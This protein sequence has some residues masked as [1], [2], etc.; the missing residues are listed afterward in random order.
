MQEIRSY[1]ARL[2]D[3]VLLLRAPYKS[4][5]QQ[6]MPSIQYAGSLF[7]QSILI[8]FDAIALE[9]GRILGLSDQELRQRH[10]NL[11]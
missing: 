2:A 10:A 6:G 8:L 11:E 5:P 4:A 3:T 9:V 7:E 1:I